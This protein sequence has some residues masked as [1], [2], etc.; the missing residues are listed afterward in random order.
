MDKYLKNLTDNL[1]GKHRLS[2]ETHGRLFL[3]FVPKVIGILYDR[4]VVRMT[5][6]T[7]GKIMCSIPKDGIAGYFPNF[8]S[9][10]EMLRVQVAG[11]LMKVIQYRLSERSDRRT[12]PAYKPPKS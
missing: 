6:E 1:I 5:P 4:E 9:G 8:P 2:A 12:W 11:S 10:K 7:L 3:E